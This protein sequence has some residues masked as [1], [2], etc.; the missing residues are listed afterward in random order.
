M[1]GPTLAKAAPSTGTGQPPAG[2]PP[3]IRDAFLA[4]YAAAGGPPELAL[5]FVDV[6][7]PCEDPR[8]DVADVSAAGHLGLLQFAPQSWD[9]VSGMTGFYDWTSAWEQ[10]YNGGVWASITDPA[11]QW[12]CW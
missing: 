7:I 6:V 3:T 2:G 4:G 8:W 11:T 12:S 1:A 10:G 9:T 5:H